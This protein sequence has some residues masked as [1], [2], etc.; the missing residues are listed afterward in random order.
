MATRL[1][2]SIIK[3][4]SDEAKHPARTCGIPVAGLPEA[5]SGNLPGLIE[6]PVACSLESV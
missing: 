5:G 1:Y 3:R 2:P 6:W 4:R